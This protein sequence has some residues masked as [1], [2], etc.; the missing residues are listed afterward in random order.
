MSKVQDRLEKFYKDETSKEELLLEGVDE[1]TK[2][3]IAGEEGTKGTLEDEEMEEQVVVR[4]YKLFKEQK[5][6]PDVS[7]AGEK[8]AEEKYGDVSFADETNKKYP[9]DKE[10]IHAAISYFGMPKNFS[11]YSMTD[12]KK[13]AS[14]IA[15]AASKFGVELSDD[16]KEKHGI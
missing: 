1:E 13:I 16:W 9:I 6:R 8:A 4:T 7:S 2:T 3:D 14:K 5:D 12:R 10:H 11:K 15:A